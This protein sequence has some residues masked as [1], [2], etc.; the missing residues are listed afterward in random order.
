MSASYS[1]VYAVTLSNG[2][3]EVS[4]LTSNSATVTDNVSNGATDQSWVL[5]DVNND[6]FTITGSGLPTNGN[7]TYLELASDTHGPN[8][9]SGFIA[10]GP[11]GQYY[12][13]TNTALKNVSGNN[14]NLTVQAGQETIC[15]MPGT[16]IRTPDGKVAVEVL[17]RGDLVLTVDGDVDPD[18][19]DRPPNRLHDLCRSAPSFANPHQ[20]WR[21]RRQH[22]HPRPTVV[23]EPRGV[24]RWS[25]CPSSSAGE[26]FLDR[27][28]N[29]GAPNLYLLS[30]RGG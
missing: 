12:F 3:Y 14:A 18:K 30:R 22:A 23:T 8:N 24:G 10:Q 9:S 28:R 29:K 26:R 5:G 15:F 6:Q 21:A 1:N 20:S 19:L 27:A 2:T 13:F 16:A 17:K 7:W 25:A 4:S 11:D